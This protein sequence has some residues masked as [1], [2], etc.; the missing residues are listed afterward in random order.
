VAVQAATLALRVDGQALEDCDVTL[1]GHDK[2]RSTAYLAEFPRWG[3]TE[4]GSRGKI[5]ATLVRTLYFEARWEELATMVPGPVLE[6]LERDSKTPEYKRLQ[7]E[8]QD[9]KDYR[10]SWAVAPYPVIFQTVDA[11]V[12]KS[13][14]ILVVR[15]KGRMGHGLI[16]L[17]GGFLNA[18]ER[19]LDGC[20]REL[21]E[22]TKIRMLK[23]DLKKHLVGSH[24]FDDPDRSQRGRTITTA[25]CFNLG[26]GDLPGVEGA[27]DADKAWWMSLRDVNRHEED[28]FEDHFAI[29]QHFTN[30]F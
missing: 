26:S 19:L 13:G 21:K 25:F 24:T 1:Y 12:I 16:A 29:I 6:F 3:F 14:H 9:I 11:V 20:L 17:P 5:D 28:F 10:A 8:Y 30:R 4:V 15:R 27:D 7:G 22:E 18:K 2:D 23:D